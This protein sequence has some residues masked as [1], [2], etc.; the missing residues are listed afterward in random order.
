MA[1][2]V[3]APAPTGATAPLWR[4]F[5]A[6]RARRSHLRHVLAAAEEWDSSGSNTDLVRR[7]ARVLRQN[8][9]ALDWS[10]QGVLAGHGFLLLAALSWAVAIFHARRHAWDGLSPLEVLPWQMLVASLVLVPLATFAEPAGR[11]PAVPPVVLTLAYVGLLGGPVAIWA[12][13]SVSRALPTLVSLLGFLGVPVLGVIVSTLWL[14][15]S[16]TLP[17]VIGAVLV[18]LGIVIV[19][20]GFDRERRREAS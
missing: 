13:T 9:L 1:D 18:L 7:C 19:A 17:L 6:T 3:S 15:E 12:A 16:L 8:P 20:L 2:D 10:R 4:A 5:T 14:G 11:L